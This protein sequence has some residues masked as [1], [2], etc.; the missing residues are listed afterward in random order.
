M[1][2]EE[3]WEAFYPVIQAARKVRDRYTPIIDGKRR[4]VL[5]CP[6]ESGELIEALNE[7]EK[8]FNIYK[9]EETQDGNKKKEINEE[10]QDGTD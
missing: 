2:F 6:D 4:P 5:V 10:K 8:K 7:A 3:V 1:N 9:K